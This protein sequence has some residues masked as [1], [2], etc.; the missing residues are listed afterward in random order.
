MSDDYKPKVDEE[1][2]ATFSTWND[3]IGT[4]YICTVV[5]ANDFTVMQAKNITTTEV[6]DIPEKN[7]QKFTITFVQI[8]IIN[9]HRR[10]SM[11]R[12]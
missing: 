9:L 3:G 4:L 10:F 6:T 7:R 5:N 2:L 11:G 1:L 8:P 12:E